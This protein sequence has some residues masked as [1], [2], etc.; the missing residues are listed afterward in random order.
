[1]VSITRTVLMLA[2]AMAVVM[3]VVPQ[4]KGTEQIDAQ[5]QR[6]DG[7]RLTK[8]NGQRVLQAGS[9]LKG[10]VDGYSNEDDRARVTSSVPILLGP[11]A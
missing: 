7:N 2:V 5:T 6:G 4:Q 9:R 8:R 10:D 11:K 1:M 3:V